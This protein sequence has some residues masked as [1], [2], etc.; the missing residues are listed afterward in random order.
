MIAEAGHLALCF[1]FV[2]SLALAIFPLYGSYKG[3][4]GP[5]L[6]ARPLSLLLFIVTAF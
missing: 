1:A 2:I 4:A 3:A 6:L 5:V